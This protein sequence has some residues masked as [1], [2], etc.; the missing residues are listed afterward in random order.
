MPLGQFGS[1]RPY[2]RTC[3]SPLLR[4]G[5]PIQRPELFQDCASGGAYG[6]VEGGYTY[7]LP[8]SMVKVASSLTY[9][10]GHHDQVVKSS[11]QVLS[12]GKFTC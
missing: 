8:G 2:V 1:L 4:K 7:L 5:F 12:F 6:D 3:G 11:S 9:S 10:N